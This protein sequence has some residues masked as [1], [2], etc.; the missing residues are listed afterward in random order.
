MTDATDMRPI[1][2]V[3]H[4]AAGTPLWSR[5]WFLALSYSFAVIV[6]LLVLNHNA[7]DYVGADNDDAMR[8]VEVRDLL[9]GQGWFDMMQ[10]RLGLSGGTLM[11]WSRFIDLPIASLIVFFRQ[12]VSPD[13]AEILA[14]TVWPLFLVIPFM[15]AMALVGR[16]LAGVPGVH[17]TLLQ[18]VFLIIT[19]VRYLPGSID[20]DNVQM[21]LVA[22]IVAML[23]DERFRASSFAVAAVAAAIAIGIGAE[24]TPFVAVACMAVGM[25]WAWE[26]A[27]FAKAASAFALTL[28]VA[29]SAA[30]FATVPPHF[31]SMVTCDNLSLGFYG[32]TTV[33]GIGLLLSALLASRLPRARRFVV[34]A[35]VGVAVL[36]SA[37]L[38]APQCLGNPLAGLDPML[39]EF[40]LSSVSEAQSIVALSVND[41]TSIGA[42]YAVG[43][44]AIVVCLFRIV[45][46]ERAQLH[47]ILLA[48]L[49]INWIIALVQVR[50]AVFANLL[51]IP[52]LTLF[53]LDLRRISNADSE[54]IRAAFFYVVG[55]L[56]SVPA[57]W[58]IGGGLARSDIGN[59]FTKSTAAADHSS[60]GSKESLAPLAAL[61]PGV[62]LAASNLG[63]PIL[64]FT[65]HRTLSGP[66][67]RDADGML[68]EMKIGMAP[69]DEARTMMQQ[70][71]VTLLAYC[72]EDPQ[73]ERFA[74]LKPEG[75]YGQLARGN[76]PAYL[77]PLPGSPKE[78]LRIF[79]V[80][81][82]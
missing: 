12:F 1:E 26:G 6:V 58:A 69:P 59:I 10:Y 66:Y 23:I 20:H 31:Y 22:L 38:L 18:T 55:V 75:L 46:G 27:A 41:P 77:D 40:W 17:I 49:A 54:D 2:G 81:Q 29:I 7:V 4:K 80:R 39:V 63:S 52:P 15:G 60:C 3:E 57:V 79:S 37:L 28:T 11:H 64:R 51:A 32:I 33:G 42:F 19:S 68:A 56:V 65:P 61:S 8:L 24:T 43:L 72:A 70:A 71:G 34:L 73:V 35:V 45:R 14:L 44:L 47:A 13:R 9:A 48:L 25:L 76:V 67:H 36:G 62:V 82:P 74:K 16:R 78:A 50:G 21:G 5:T 53:V 30:F